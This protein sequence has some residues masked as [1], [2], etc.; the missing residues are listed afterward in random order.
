[1]NYSNTLCI[2]I[3]AEVTTPP[4]GPLTLPSGLLAALRLI[5]VGGRNVVYGGHLFT[6]INLIGSI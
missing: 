2:A 5:S 4:P 6:G 1:M 3:I